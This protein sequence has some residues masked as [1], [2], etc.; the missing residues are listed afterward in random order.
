MVPA[1]NLSERGHMNPWLGFALCLGFWLASG[2]L[3]ARAE[4]PTRVVIVLSESGPV[5]Q[6]VVTAFTAALGGKYPVQTRV[7]AEMSSD[8]IKSLN[9]E[10]ILIVPVGV[11]AMR[12]VHSI[13]GHRAQIL[14]LLV[15][16]AALRA[17]AD[18]AIDDTAVFI[19]QPP[20]RMLAFT[21]LILPKA[22][23]VGV[24]ISDE[25]AAG[26]R[27]MATD[28]ERAGLELVAETVRDSEEVPR[29]L[30]RLL[31]Q[32]DAL[33]LVPDA[34][35][36]NE[37]SVRHILIASYRQRIPVI[38]FSRGLVHAGAVAALVTSPNEIGRQGGLLARQWNPGVGNLPAARYAGQ[39]DLVFNRQ[40]A[41]SLAL[42]LPADEQELAVWRRK[43]D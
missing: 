1:V 31:P 17:L 37:N 11:R 5:Y 29:A 8:E 38:G 2:L 39:F 35:V 16:N 40:L 26:V 22:Q 43:L 34:N 18:N 36:V 28:A 19:D 7:V 6:D 42:D 25:A 33:L 23:K 20:A 3:P 41:R 27:G 13:S 24:V 4:T 21:K 12:A 10:R 15:P 14:S 9:A 30:Q 32:V